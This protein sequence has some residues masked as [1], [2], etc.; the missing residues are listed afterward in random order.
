MTVYEKENGNYC[1]YPV[2]SSAFESKK[3]NNVVL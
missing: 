3:A 1:Y 2:L